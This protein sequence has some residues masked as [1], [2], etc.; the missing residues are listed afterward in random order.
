M[1]ERIGGDSRDLPLWVAP[2]SLLLLGLALIAAVIALASASTL[3]ENGCEGTLGL[4]R[5]LQIVAALVGLLPTALV[6]FFAY[7]DHRRR[8]IVAI[9]MSLVVYAVWGVLLELLSNP[10]AHGVG[11]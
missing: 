11:T 7:R 8:M 4:I 5:K 6:V 1:P 10:T 3:C 2:A 9:V